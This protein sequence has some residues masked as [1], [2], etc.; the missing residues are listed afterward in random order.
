ME[1][2]SHQFKKTAS[3][4]LRDQKVQSALG[5]A[6]G[7]F[8]VARERAVKELDNL[9]EIRQAAADMRSHCLENLDSYL[10]EWEKNATAKGTVVH[11]AES[12]EELNSLVVEIAKRNNV[13][14]KLSSPNR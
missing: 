2:T 7:K 13:K 10:E 11:W 1:I 5:K 9:E 8:V 14:K 3:L 12:A 4:K 6:K